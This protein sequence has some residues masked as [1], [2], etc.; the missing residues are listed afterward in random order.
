MSERS[1]SDNE[2]QPKDHVND[3]NAGKQSRYA[4]LDVIENGQEPEV[5]IVE[6]LLFIWRCIIHD[7]KTTRA[8]R[9]RQPE[10]TE[11]KLDH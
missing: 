10:T 2:H 7:Q 1:W 4:T 5:F 11:K 3:G 6:Y 9:R 8:G